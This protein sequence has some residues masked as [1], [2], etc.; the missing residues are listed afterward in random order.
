MASLRQRIGRDV[1]DYQI[2][3][4]CLASLSKPRDRV[5]RLLAAGDI[6]RLRKGLYLF[7]ERFRREPVCREQLA[8]LIHGPSYVS[9]DYALSFHGLIPERV[10]MLTS[11]CTGRSRVF[12][13]PVGMFSYR[14]LTTQRYACGAELFGVSDSSFLMAKPAKALAD[15]VWTDKRFAGTRLR[16]FDAYLFED[17]RID[18]TVLAS[19]PARDLMETA[20]AYDSPKIHRLAKFVTRLQ[21][22]R[23]A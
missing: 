9:L 17:L 12:R 15:K 6:I 8:N 13:T 20:A 5:R 7:A 1:F 19:L 23:D 3:M 22:R 18:R 2:L 11:V 21:E 16:D 4:D 14:S 10:E